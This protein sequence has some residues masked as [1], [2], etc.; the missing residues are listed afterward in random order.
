MSKF[1]YKTAELGLIAALVAFIVFITGFYSG[2]TKKNIDELSAP[3][4]AAMG[5]LAVTKKTNADALKAFGFDLSRTDGIAYYAAD[6]VMDVSEVL[7]VKLR[8]EK[9][10]S[11]F[12]EAIEDRVTNQKNLYK[13]Y[14]PMQYSL[15]QNCIIESSGNTVFY[16]TA[17]NANAIYDAYANAL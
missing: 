3:V 9:D 10:A 8:D 12:K 7:V 13:N 17:T 1:F 2:G 4:E 6:N 15:L 16:C 11:D 5:E 14:A